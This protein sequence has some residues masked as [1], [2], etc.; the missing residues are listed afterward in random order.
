MVEYNRA[1]DVEM[2]IEGNTRMLLSEQPFEGQLAILDG[3]AAQVS[4]FDLDQVER[5]ERGGMTVSVAA[6]Q[7]EHRKAIVVA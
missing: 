7:L 4:A 3:L 5:A 1:F 2:S 6:K